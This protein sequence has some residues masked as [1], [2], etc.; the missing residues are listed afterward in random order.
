MV[1]RRQ[2]GVRHHI[3]F[4]VQN[5]LYVAEGHVKQQT[6]P[7]GQRFQKPDMGYWAGQLDMS[8]PLSTDLSQ[9]HFD[10]TLLADHAAVLQA[11]VLTTQTLVVLYRAK[12]LGAEQTIALWLEG[13]IVD[14]LGLFDFAKRPRPNHFRRGKTDTDR[15]EVFVFLPAQQV[16]QISHVFSPLRSQMTQTRDQYRYRASGFL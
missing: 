16:Q 2:P 7:R 14:G 15:I 11:L 12:D 4:E 9:C 13:S 8:H 3:G 6:D 5:A 10:T 1:Q